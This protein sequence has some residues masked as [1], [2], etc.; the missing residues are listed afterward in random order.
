MGTGHCNSQGPSVQNSSS[1]YRR[2]TDW[3]RTY[4]EHAS[5]R[6]KQAPTVYR[7]SVNASCKPEGVLA[8]RCRHYG[9]ASVSGIYLA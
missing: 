5:T 2:E 4:Y 1:L 7:N 8:L 9:R 3:V 6:V